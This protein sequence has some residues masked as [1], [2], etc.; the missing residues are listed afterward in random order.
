MAEIKTLDALRD[1]L[2]QPHSMTQQ[3]IY[4]ALFDEA[5]DFI[6]RAPLLFMATVSKDGA[7]TVS[8]KG[9]GPGFV[10]VDD[11]GT[12]LIPERPGNKLAFGLTNILETGRIGL[13]F[14]IPG[15]EETLR[16]NGTCVLDDDPALCAKLEAR[17]QDAILVMRVSVEECFFHCAKAFKRS[18]TWQPDSWGDAFKINFGEMMARNAGGNKL[19]Q[20]A[21][22]VAVNQAV[23]QDYKHNL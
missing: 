17:G 23:K 14:L 5:V 1:R 20:K 21:V 10:H 16:V 3:K 18:Q 4:D 13:I 2:G 22:E 7:A 11:D 8:P 19:K 6:A 9:D 12:L 15:T